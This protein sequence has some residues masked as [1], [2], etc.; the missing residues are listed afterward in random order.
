MSFTT[1][2]IFCD[3]FTLL[4]AVQLTRAKL[5]KQVLFDTQEIA[6]Q[7]DKEEEEEAEWLKMDEPPEW[8]RRKKTE[9]EEYQDW[10]PPPVRKQQV[11]S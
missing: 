11:V 9:F 7:M 3:S 8:L 1:N 6:I 4:I 2:F 5:G 10:Q